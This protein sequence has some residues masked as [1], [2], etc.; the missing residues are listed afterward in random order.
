MNLYT[1]DVKKQRAHAILDDV[2]AGLDRTQWE[3]TWALRALGEPVTER[4]S[5]AIAYVSRTLMSI[6]PSVPLTGTSKTS[7]GNSRTLNAS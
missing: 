7:L 1:W 3:I 6:T 5:Y 2:K 4:K